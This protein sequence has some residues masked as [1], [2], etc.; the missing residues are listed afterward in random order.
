M[1]V[2]CQRKW[3][4]SA[5]MKD[6][7]L[8][9]GGTG[10][11][12]QAL[13]RQLIASGYD[14]RS[15]I[16]PSKKT[17][18]LP[19]GVPVDVVVASYS[20]IRGIRA[21]MNGVNTIIHLVSGENKGSNTDLLAVDIQST[22]VIATAAA[23]AGVERI[24]YISHL[25]ADR[26]SAYPSLKTKGISESYIRSSGLDFTIFRSALVYGPSDHL[27]EGIKNLLLASPFIFLLPG[28]GSTVLQPIW[29]EDMV[30]CILSSLEDDKTRN[31]TFEI[32]GGEYLSIHEIVEIIKTKTSIKKRIINIH[33][34]YLRIITV[35]FENLFPSFPVSTFWLDYL[36]ANRSCA[37]DSLPREFGILPAKFDQKLEYLKVGLNKIPYSSFIKKPNE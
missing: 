35:I 18:N 28:D 37:I 29:I 25:G 6:M 11:I 36:S 31:K 34:A 7:L 22:K 33:P 21:A 14:V 20:D 30:G 32:G 10:F 24:I 19:K 23:E 15:L 3:Y 1:Q 5:I 12:G 8:V 26:A 16:R 2:V 4:S 17:P 9:T 27:T 13:I